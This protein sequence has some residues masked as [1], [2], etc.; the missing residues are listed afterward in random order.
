MLSWFID[1]CNVVEYVYSRGV[2]YWDFKLSNVM[3]G[4]YGE[5]LVIDWGFVKVK[6]WEEVYEGGDEMIF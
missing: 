6:G 5:I 3:L 2:L 1:V 4:K